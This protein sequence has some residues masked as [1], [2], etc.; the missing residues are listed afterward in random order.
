MQTIVFPDGIL[1]VRDFAGHDG[2]FIWSK[3]SIWRDMRPLPARVAPTPVDPGQ[4]RPIPCPNCGHPQY[5][6]FF[7][8]QLPHQCD[9]CFHAFAVLA[10]PCLSWVGVKSAL[11]NANPWA[12]KGYRKVI[13]TYAGGPTI[14][15]YDD[16]SAPEKPAHLLYIS[17]GTNSAS[18]NASGDPRGMLSDPSGP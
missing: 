15:E 9:A 14:E 10:V 11:P 7:S 6:V 12:H 13:P 2:L 8:S 4:I 18:I 1:L 5:F 3:S 17:T 16:K